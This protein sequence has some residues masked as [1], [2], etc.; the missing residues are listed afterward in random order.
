MPGAPSNHAVYDTIVLILVL[1]FSAIIAPE[2]LCADRRSQVL[3]LYLVRPLSPADYLAGRWLAFFTICAGSGVFRAIRTVRRV[4]AQRRGTARPTC[5]RT[6]ST[7]RASWQTGA[8]ASVFATTIPLVVAGFTSRRAYAAA[9]VIGLIF[10][11]VGRRQ[12]ARWRAPSSQTHMEGNVVVLDRCEPVTGEYAKW[13]GLARS[14]QRAEAP[15]RQDPGIKLSHRTC[16][17]RWRNSTSRS[18]S[19]GTWC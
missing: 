5:G 7:S 2:L 6:G 12:P 9:F 13:I 19:Y 1:L 4:N 8:I 3:Q 14:R 16:R 18:Q 11:S 17:C 10:I 15:E